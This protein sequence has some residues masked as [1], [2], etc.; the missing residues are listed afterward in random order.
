MQKPTS[1][2]FYVCKR[3]VCIHIVHEMIECNIHQV[4]QGGHGFV[5]AGL[6]VSR[7]AKHCSK[8]F[9]VCKSRCYSSAE[10]QRHL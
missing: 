7:C 2:V 4:H 8:R 1:C 3:G 5:W 10:C 6:P 9:S